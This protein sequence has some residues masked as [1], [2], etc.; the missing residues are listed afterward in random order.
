MNFRKHFDYDVKAGCRLFMIPPVDKKPTCCG[1]GVCAL[2][3]D[4]NPIPP[5]HG[6]LPV[7]LLSAIC[8]CVTAHRNTHR[9]L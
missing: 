6:A 9:M 4:S 7:E 1:L 8:L 2:S 3:R 5:E